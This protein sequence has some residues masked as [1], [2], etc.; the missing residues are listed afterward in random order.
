MGKKCDL[1]VPIMI[2]ILCN[3]I[4]INIQYDYKLINKKY[5][6]KNRDKILQNKKKIWYCDVCRTEFRLSSKKN[7]LKTLT[8]RSKAVCL[9]D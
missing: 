7:H 4:M 8:H 5:Y 1:K 2:I 9:L 6:D 3:Y